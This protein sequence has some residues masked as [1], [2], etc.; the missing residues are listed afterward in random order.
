MT[1]LRKITFVFPNT[2]EKEYEWNS[3]FNRLISDVPTAQ[4]NV[5][6]PSFSDTAMPSTGFLVGLSPSPTILLETEVSIQLKLGNIEITNDASANNDQSLLNAESSTTIKMN[7]TARANTISY[8]YEQLKGRIIGID[9]TGVNV[10]AATT[11]QSVWDE[12]MSRLSGIC[13][14][15]RYP[16]QQWPFIIPADD[17]EYDTE[18]SNFNVKRTPKFEIVYDTYTDKPIFQFALETNITKEELE[19]IFPEPIGFAIPGLS[20]IFRSVVVQSPWED[21]VVFRFDLYYKPTSKELTDWETGEWL[22]REGGR[23]KSE[24]QDKDYVISNDKSKIDKQVVLDYLARSY[25]ANKREPERT[26]RAIE[27]SDC[28]GIYH[29]EKQVGFARIVTDGA[30]MFYLCDVFVLEEYQGQSLGKK[31]IET[32]VNDVKY[33]SLMGMLGTLDAHGLYEQYGFIKDSDRFMK[34]PP[35]WANVPNG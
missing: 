12:F 28:Y 23:V 15:Y 26:L 1:R 8:L 33:E 24:V 22:V 9:H 18:I 10:P 31:L 11:E 35:T 17:K 5:I 16:G 13:N 14:L 2:N 30:T 6:V 4:S 32:I 34:R 20:D 3:F 7:S 25:W 21:E 27:A 29:H 19:S